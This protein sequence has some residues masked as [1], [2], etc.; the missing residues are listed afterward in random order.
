MHM[1]SEEKIE[2]FWKWFAQNEQHIRKG[3]HSDKMVE[4]LNSHILAFG[5]F[6]WDIDRDENGDFCLTISPNGSADRLHI[7]QQIIGGAPSLP[8]WA[9]NSSKPAT[10]W[11]YQL[12]MYDTN[13]DL[14]SIDASQWKFVVIPE[15][16]GK[17]ELII[18]AQ[19]VHILHEDDQWVAGDTAVTHLLGEELK[20]QSL[21]A[22]EVTTQ[23]ES[24][25]E[26]NS[27]PLTELQTHFKTQFGD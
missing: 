13:V 4:G 20:I 3:E 14:Q 16:D 9:F 26:E 15:P 5:L 12:E 1:V 7:S 2:A 8:Y 25:E 23:F 10:D 18:C 17:V 11:N 22:L 27:K 6:A 19:N 24:E 21:A